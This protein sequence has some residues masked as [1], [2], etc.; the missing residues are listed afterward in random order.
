MFFIIRLPEAL[1]LFNIIKNKD[2]TY[3][4]QKNNLRRGFFIK[5]QGECA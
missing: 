4:W 3:E 5:N 2:R 1:K